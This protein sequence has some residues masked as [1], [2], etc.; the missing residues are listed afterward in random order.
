MYNKK[1]FIPIVKFGK[2]VFQT[3]NFFFFFFST[4]FRPTK[5]ERLIR[6]VRRGMRIGQAL[7]P[8]EIEPG[9]PRIRHWKE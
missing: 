8:L 5:D 7:F 6:L 4:G 1:K 2:L 9:I 3:Q